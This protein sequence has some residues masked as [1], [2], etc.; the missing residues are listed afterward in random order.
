MK[1]LIFGNG[2][3]ASHL[4][5]D[6]RRFQYKVHS[7]E[8]VKDAVSFY[9]P[10][11]I[12]N[13]IGYGGVKNIDDCEDGRNKTYIANTILPLI[14]SEVCRD[15]NIYLAHIGSGCIFYGESPNIIC[16]EE[17]IGRN[18]FYGDEVYKHICHDNGWRETD[19]TIPQSFYSRTKY[20]SDLILSQLENTSVLRLRMPI[21]PKPNP[22]NIITKI[23]KYN[24]LLNA[25]NSLTFLEDFAPILDKFVNERIT[26]VYHV[27]NPTPLS[28]VDIMN[29]YK[30]YVPSHSFEEINEEQL[31]E[32]TIAKRSTCILNT[33][34]L[35]G[36]GIKMLDSAELIESTIKRYVNGA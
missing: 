2:F 4:N 10:D 25:K 28:P 15:N 8:D 16:S 17:V 11:A 36:L 20:A 32:I 3:V 1:T 6:F 35:N 34:K 31:D 9:K 7:K 14:I 18:P 12:I 24:K 22:R 13:C 21:S 26:G 33:D 29:E 30:K 19:A 27:T 5:K 23:S